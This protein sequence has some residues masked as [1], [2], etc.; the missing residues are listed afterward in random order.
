[1][2]KSQHQFNGGCMGISVND[3]GAIV[4]CEGRKLILNLTTYG[5]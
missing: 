5:R 4:I 1:L 3:D 2:T